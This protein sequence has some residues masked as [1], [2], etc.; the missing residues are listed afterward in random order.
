MFKLINTTPEKVVLYTKDI[1]TRIYSIE[2]CD[3]PITLTRSKP[4]LRVF[5]GELCQ[6]IPVITGAIPDGYSD[7]G[8]LLL[9]KKPLLVTRDVA[10]Y[11]RYFHPEFYKVELYVASGA[12]K[13]GTQVMW[14]TKLSLF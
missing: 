1:S 10:L 3:T 6:K 8:N 11:I 4:K 13:D 12:I 9:G 2:P 7:P 5:I 14:Y